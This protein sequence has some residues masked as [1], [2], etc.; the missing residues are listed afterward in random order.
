[1]AANPKRK[2]M[3]TL[4]I[5]LPKV[6]ATR[7]SKQDSSGEDSNPRLYIE[8]GFNSH[9][10]ES[11]AE[12]LTKSG[13]IEAKVEGE[14][15]SAL[16]RGP[17]LALRHAV[18]TTARGLAAARIRNEKGRSQSNFPLR[19]EVDQEEAALHAHTHHEYT[20]KA[21]LP[22]SSDMVYDGES[23]QATFR[24]LLPEPGAAANIV[25]TGRMLASWDEDAKTWVPQA[26]VPG[27]PVLVGIGSGE[28]ATLAAQVR[29]ALAQ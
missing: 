26:V 27:N 11:L 9:A 20:A 29:E 24:E 28:T 7:R 14:M 3:S 6:V 13:G 15:I 1:M 17:Q 25:V 8:R 22:E 18:A 2:G 10:A 4:P 21:A 16:P 12:G 23:V 19:G 5:Y